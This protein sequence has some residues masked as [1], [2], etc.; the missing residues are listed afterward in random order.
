MSILITS[1]LVVLLTLFSS[2]AFVTR[3]VLSTFDDKEI[4]SR[5]STSN[6]ERDVI[7]LSEEFHPRDWQN[8]SNLKKTANY[9]TKVFVENGASVFTQEFEVQGITYEN[10]VGEFWPK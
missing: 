5:V 1:S 10:V 3:P 8:T 7:L 6:L 9:I 2:T 4:V